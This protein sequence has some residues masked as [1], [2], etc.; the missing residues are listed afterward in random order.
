[1][2]INALCQYYDILADKGKMVG[3]GYSEVNVRYMVCLKNTG[4]IENII[5]CQIRELRPDKKGKSKEVTYP[6]KV[7]M[8]KR[9]EKTAID[10]NIIEHRPEYIFGLNYDNNGFTPKDDKSTVAKKYEAFKGKTLSFLEGLNSPV[11]NAYREFIKNW[12][13][14][15][16]TGNPFLTDLGKN[17]SS[18]GYA[19]CLAGRSDQPLHEDGQIRKKW[20]KIFANAKADQKDVVMAQCAVSGQKSPISRIHGKI[21]GINGGQPSGTV[22]VGFNNESECSYGKEQSYNS[23][24]S[25][26]VMR[27]YTK[28]LN[29]LLEGNKHKNLIDETTVFFW[30]MGPNE[31]ND[32]LFNMLLFGGSQE[33]NSEQTEKILSDLIG[34]MRNGELCRGNLDVLDK[35]DPEVDFYILGLKPNAS[36]LSVKFLYRRKFGELL[37]NVARHQEDLSI[38]DNFKPI[39][40][41]HIKQELVSPKSSAEKINPALAAKIFEA[42]VYGSNYPLY[43]LETAVRRVKT[44]NDMAVNALRAGIIKACIN[45]KLRLAKK[46]EVFKLALDKE[47]MDQ[48]YLCGRLFAVL[49]RIQEASVKKTF[50]KT[51]EKPSDKGASGKGGELNRTIKQAYFSSAASSPALIFPKLLKLAQH[52][53]N[54]LEKPEYFN[55]LLGEI[56]WNLG[57]AFPKTLDLISQGTFILGYYQ[58]RQSFFE[59]NKE[60]EEN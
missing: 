46:K 5:D 36:R 11:I 35:I 3:E 39:S 23:S 27:K 52:H 47:N 19:F 17:Y 32:D 38:G 15:K 28:A 44:D 6:R 59:K 50:D 18:A 51:A 30:A 58:Q 22:L 54:K 14:E 8:P 34:Y 12:Q 29:Y 25:E 7:I 9:T 21:K 43:L 53:L 10:S 45:R 24:I 33:K 40:L 42:I 55:I 4:E 26:I 56:M 41:W 48:A 60:K 1:M 2:L 31:N 57:T 13:P 37:L 16:E 49:E 20:D